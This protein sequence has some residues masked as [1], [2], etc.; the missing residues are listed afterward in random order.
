V[1][2]LLNPLCEKDYDFASDDLEVCCIS[3]LELEE[4]DSSDSDDNCD[5]SNTSVDEV[6]SQPSHAAE[7]SYMYYLVK[8]GLSYRQVEAVMSLT[9]R[10]IPKAMSMLKPVSRQTASK[11]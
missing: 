6:T 9:R 3:A 8:I 7:R 5:E 1:G 2:S 10:T 4:V 11:G